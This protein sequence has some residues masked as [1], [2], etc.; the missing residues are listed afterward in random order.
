MPI[1]GK[2]C[3]TLYTD[4]VETL[5]KEKRYK[6]T[7]DQ[8]LLNLLLKSGRIKHIGQEIRL[9]EGDTGK[10]KGEYPKS[11]GGEDNDQKRRE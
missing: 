1:K 11:A 5:G 10:R 6:E 2:S 3:I 7:W 4:T 9:R 8:Y